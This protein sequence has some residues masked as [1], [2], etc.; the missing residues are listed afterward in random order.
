[1]LQFLCAFSWVQAAICYFAIVFI[2]F[3][4]KY[5]SGLLR[6]TNVSATQL[7]DKDRN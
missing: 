7:A 5:F 6:F 2:D 3:S 1:M 4:L